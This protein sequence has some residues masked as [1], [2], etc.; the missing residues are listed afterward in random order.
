M[1][2]LFTIPLGLE[3][4]ESFFAFATCSN[5]ML[6]SIKCAILPKADMKQASPSRQLRLVNQ[7]FSTDLFMPLIS[8]PVLE[9]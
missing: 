3:V 9:I 8:I 6:V 5:E 2:F 4:W 7:Y 1:S